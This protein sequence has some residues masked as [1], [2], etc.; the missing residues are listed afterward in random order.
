M[1]QTTTAEVRLDPGTPGRFSALAQLVG[2]F[3][4]LPR[5]RR[6]I[7]PLPKTPEGTISGS[8][9]PGIRGMSV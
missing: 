5:A 7:L 1:R 3:D 9:P 6:A 4:R 8:L 2:G